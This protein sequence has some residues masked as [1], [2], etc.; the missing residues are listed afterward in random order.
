MNCNC[1]NCNKETD[2]NENLEEFKWTVIDDIV[3][4]NDILNNFNFS[5]NMTVKEIKELIQERLW[6][7]KF[8][9]NFRTFNIINNDILIGK[10]TVARMKDVDSE[11][12][13]LAFTFCDIS[14]DKYS[15]KEGERYSLHRI[16]CDVP[17]IPTNSKF[18]KLDN[19]F[20]KTVGVL[21]PFQAFIDDITDKE[22][23]INML[24]KSIIKSANSMG[25]I[26]MLGLTT[27][28]IK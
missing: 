7:D 3:V 23:H 28:N 13:K 5:N 10:V 18:T 17:N 12:I 2:K 1:E 27:E 14:N 11:Y 20:A 16:L 8:K 25:I 19:D 26:W 22:E 21:L 9:I 6:I 15:K 24:K 4:L